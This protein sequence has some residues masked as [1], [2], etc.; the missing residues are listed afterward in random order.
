MI[1]LSIIIFILQLQEMQIDS[2]TESKTTDSPAKSAKNL[3]KRVKTPKQG[4]KTKV[5][6]EISKEVKTIFKVYISSVH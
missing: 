3:L 1:Y 2:E 5:E 4:N 6:E